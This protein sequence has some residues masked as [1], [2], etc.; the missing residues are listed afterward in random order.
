MGCDIMEE[1]IKELL[2]KN[3]GIVTTKQIEEICISRVYIK[4]LVD[5]GIINKVKKG[6]Y[7]SSDIFEDEFYIF[8]L[9][10]KIAIFSYNTALYLQKATE[11]TPDK[12][13]VTVYSGYNKQRFQSNIRTHY[14]QKEFLNI[15]V[16]TVESPQGF[17]VKAYNL[18]RT[19]CDILKNRNTGIDKEQTN[20]FIRNMIVHNQVD[21]NTVY[22]YAK[23]L[24]CTKQ[25]ETVMEWI[26]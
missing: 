2:K 19:I 1:K 15:G 16:I 6:I 20:K 18:E 4:Q 26:I 9:K 25:L 17:N 10:N 8:Q 23:K 3:K 21:I 11:R 13:D 14:V 5:K 22:D 7:I 24:K 12:L